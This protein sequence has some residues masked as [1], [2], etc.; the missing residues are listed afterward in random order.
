MTAALLRTCDSWLPSKD[1]T[2]LAF[3]NPEMA[4]DQPIWHPGSHQRQQCH[5]CNQESGWS[6]A[7]SAPFFFWQM[8]LSKGPS[9]TAFI[10][11]YYV[12]LQKMLKSSI[13]WRRSSGMAEQSEF[14]HVNGI[15]FCVFVSDRIFQLLHLLSFSLSSP[16]ILRR[17]GELKCATVAFQGFSFIPGWNKVLDL[18]RPWNASFGNLE[19]DS[20]SLW[21]KQRGCFQTS[22]G[23]YLSHRGEM[24][25]NESIL[26]KHLQ[27]TEGLVLVVKLCRA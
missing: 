13:V 1:F 16:L 17:P 18:F 5:S 14:F 19:P 11:K 6:V 22:E 4:W 24:R 3:I 8:S 26:T 2:V 12:D 21:D 7:A 9:G 25:I 27:N 10:L 15:F 20:R 23:I